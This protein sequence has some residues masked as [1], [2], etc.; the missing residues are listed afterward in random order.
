MHLSRA[1]SFWHQVVLAIKQ[2]DITQSPKD[3]AG[4]PLDSSPGMRSFQDSGR[5]SVGP[6][7]VRAR[8][9]IQEGHYERAL[10]GLNRPGAVEKTQAVYHERVIVGKFSPRRQARDSAKEDIE[11]E[12]S[13]MGHSTSMPQLQSS[14]SFIHHSESI[15]TGERDAST[16]PSWIRRARAV[17][18][19]PPNVEIYKTPSAGS[20]FTMRSPASPRGQLRQQALGG[21][22]QPAL[23][24]GSPGQM[25]RQTTPISPRMAI[26][27]TASLNSESERTRSYQPS[28]EAPRALVIPNSTS[29][30]LSA[31]KVPTGRAQAMSPV[32][33]TLL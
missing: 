8:I 5:N 12:C 19:L 4:I 13:P 14:S 20:A 21:S 6:K 7:S 28:T 24:S 10:N 23:R 30:T 26:A 22:F 27:N 32:R 9:A 3:P 33:S 2:R 15:P 31:M 16:T 17:H 25:P 11:S 1:M 18:P 29:T